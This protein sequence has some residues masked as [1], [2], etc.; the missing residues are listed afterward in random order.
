MGQSNEPLPPPRGMPMTPEPAR[1]GGNM[2]CKQKPEEPLHGPFG[3][4]GGQRPPNFGGQ[5]PSEVKPRSSGW[6]CCKE[7][8]GQNDPAFN[9]RSLQPAPG[10]LGPYGAPKDNRS[11]TGAMYTGICGEDHHDEG[12]YARQGGP[13]KQADPYMT[14]GY[15]EH[16]IWKQQDLQGAGAAYGQQAQQYGNQA[17]SMAASYWGQGQA[18]AQS[19][20]KEAQNTY[21]AASMIGQGYFNQA[22]AGAANYQQQAQAQ[23]AQYQQQAQDQGGGFFS[24]IFGGGDTQPQMQNY[25][26]QGQAYANQG[27]A[28][29]QQYYNQGAQQASSLFSMGQSQVNQARNQFNQGMQQQQQPKSSSWF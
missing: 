21:G 27:K 7:Q 23:A 28:Q 4:L 20:Q 15:D 16:R 3:S 29:A 17:Q 11:C 10:E 13:Y 2:C 1:S 12:P 8:S 6:W 22:K 5:R 14:K 25:Q 24:S 19:M 9:T 18:Q 26:Q